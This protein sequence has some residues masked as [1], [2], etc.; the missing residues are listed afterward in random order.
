MS[1][2][3]FENLTQSLHNLKIDSADPNLYLL[4]VEDILNFYSIP[5][6]RVN[7]F[8]VGILTKGEVTMTINADSYHLKQGSVVFMNPWYMRKYSNIMN[9]EGYVLFFT[10]QYLCQFQGS[11]S[12]IKEFPFF[13]V[14]NKM[15]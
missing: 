7:T 2:P 6:F 3:Y 10:P 9:W 15:V 11:D 13:N 4:K 5:T 12:F 14:E 1:I 8:W